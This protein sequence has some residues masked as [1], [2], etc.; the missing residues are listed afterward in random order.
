MARE[1]NSGYVIKD[2]DTELEQMINLLLE[3]DWL[4]EQALNEYPNPLTDK[5]KF[6]QAS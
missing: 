3:F 6:T 5:N 1:Q 4:I 2:I